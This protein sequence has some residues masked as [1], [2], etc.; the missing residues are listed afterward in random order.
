MEAMERERIKMARALRDFVFDATEE[1]L[2]ADLNESGEDFESLASLGKAVAERALKTATEKSAVV[3][4]LRR[5]LGMLIQMLRRRE[6]LS[7][8][9]LA[10][11]ASIDLAELRSI[12][13]DPGWDPHPRTIFQL[14]KFFKLPPRSLVVLSGAMRVEEGIR[15]EALRFAANSKAVNKLTREEKKVLAAFVKFLGEQTNR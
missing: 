1:E 2:R 8:D 9:D 10:R 7:P 3:L 14:A 5:C 15:E 13:S 12:E 11:A 6:R 4:D